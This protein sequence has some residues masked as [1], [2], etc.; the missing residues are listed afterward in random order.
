MSAIDLML[1]EENELTFQLTIEGT[2]PAEAS[3]RLVLNNSDMS[4]VFEADEFSNGEVSVVLPPLHHVLKEGT[5]DMDLEVIVDDRYFKPLTL[6]GN[7]EKGLVVKASTSSKTRK[8]RRTQPTVRLSEAA[9]D[10]TPV[11]SVKNSKTK[12]KAATLASSIR[13][14]KNKKG[15]SETKRVM[16][17]KDISDED[18]LNIIKALTKNQ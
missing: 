12:S 14:Q 8:K 1:D 7:F 10:T 17:S 6:E 2:R 4:L 13:S 3:A 9:A 18:I 5:Y 11:V 15:I 16:S